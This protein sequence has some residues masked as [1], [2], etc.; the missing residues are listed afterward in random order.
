MSKV[1]SVH[2]SLLPQILNALLH[3]R[4]MVPSLHIFH[5]Q[6]TKNAINF[7][8]NSKEQRIHQC[9][10]R[11]LKAAKVVKL[12]HVR[13]DVNRLPLLLSSSLSNSEND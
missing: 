13:F 5:E 12:K 2:S 4:V 10:N 11:K 1:I 8:Y 6:H 3:T 9:K 7:W